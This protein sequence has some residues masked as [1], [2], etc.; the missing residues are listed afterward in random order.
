[1]AD[2]RAITSGLV[3]NS[4]GVEAGGGTPTWLD[5]EW[6]NVGRA[7]CCCCCCAVVVARGGSASEL[8]MVFRFASTESCAGGSGGVMGDMGGG[9]GEGGRE[10]MFVVMVSAGAMI[11]AE[12]AGPAARISSRRRREVLL[13]LMPRRRVAEYLEFIG[14]ARV[15]YGALDAWAGT[16]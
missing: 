11:S 9:T 14:Q 7:D 12:C 5:C 3:S 6:V 2:R 8:T 13:T 1:M 16:G 15:V 4:M 10:F